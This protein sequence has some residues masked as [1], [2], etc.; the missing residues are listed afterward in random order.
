MRTVLRSDRTASKRVS[1]LLTWAGVTAFTVWAIVVLSVAPDLVAEAQWLRSASFAHARYLGAQT[2]LPATGGTT[3]LAGAN[4]SV[5]RDTFHR[6][7]L[8][9]SNGVAWD[10]YFRDSDEPVGAV[11]LELGLLAPPKIGEQYRIRYYPDHP[12]TAKLQLIPGLDWIKFWLKLGYY[13]FFLLP[14]AY[15]LRA[16]QTERRSHRRDAEFTQRAQ[17]S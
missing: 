11:L 6:Y 14:I 5:G 2:D 13:A 8:I 3:F 1:T 15:L 4:R 12:E 9:Q 16:G 17:R 10:V 7:R